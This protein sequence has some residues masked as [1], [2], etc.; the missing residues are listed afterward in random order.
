MVAIA[1][2]SV[3]LYI[4]LLIIILNSA[5]YL[6]NNK[7]LTYLHDCEVWRLQCTCK[8]EWSTVEWYCFSALVVISNLHWIALLNFEKLVVYLLVNNILKSIK[9]FKEGGTSI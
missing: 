5:Y 3:V 6:T 9:G 7:M 8:L 1:A 4:I 2:L